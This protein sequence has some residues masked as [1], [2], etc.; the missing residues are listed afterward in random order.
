M[1]PKPVKAVLFD[2]DGLL[3]DTEAVY[4]EALQA[5][6]AA[7]GLEMSLSFC[8]SMIGLPSL[9]C[10][11]MIQDLYGPDFVL[12]TFGAHFDVHTHRRLETGVPVKAGAVELLDF[13][14][15]HRLP[16]AVATSSSQAT[17]KK[18]LGRAGLLD[19][20][21]AVATRDDVARSKPDPDVYL[22]AARRLGVAPESCVAFEDSNAGLTA[23][24]AAGTMPIMVP[25][26]VPPTE[27]VRAKCLQ[28]V[29]DLH[30]AL[31]LLREWATFDASAADASAANVSAASL[32]CSPPGRRA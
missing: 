4:T 5:A 15:Q 29:P 14:K 30:A 13:L 3:I 28:V 16:L 26:I 18:H 6:A 7:M 17:V 9:V 1:F 19:R 25:D 2:M 32:S 11:G 22:E 31:R 8:H 24:H 10:D 23:A 20:F 27:E 12:E 21:G